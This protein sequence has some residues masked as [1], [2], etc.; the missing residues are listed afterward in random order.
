MNYEFWA[1]FMNYINPNDI[2]NNKT[3]SQK[4][5]KHSIAKIYILDYQAA[6]WYVRSY[7]GTLF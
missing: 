6:D 1:K 2:I 3:Q 4:I 7:F 5:N